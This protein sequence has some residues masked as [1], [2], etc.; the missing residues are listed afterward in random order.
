VMSPLFFRDGGLPPSAER[1]V[2]RR[3]WRSLRFD[4]AFDSREPYFNLLWEGKSPLSGT[5]VSRLGSEGWKLVDDRRYFNLFNEVI[6]AEVPSSVRVLVS[7]T[8]DRNLKREYLRASQLA[9]KFSDAMMKT[10]GWSMNRIPSGLIVLLQSPSGNTLGGG[11]V[12][13]AGESAYLFGGFVLK[14]HR[15]KGYWKILASVRQALSRIQGARSWC[16]ITG[17]PHIRNQGTR[18]YSTRWFKHFP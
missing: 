1:E 2:L 5:L 8:D 12:Y 16:Y 9:F 15:S 18:M 11:A 13:W 10:I 17:N 7:S 3:R 4:S 14:P 6:E